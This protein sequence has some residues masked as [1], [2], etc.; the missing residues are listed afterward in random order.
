MTFSVGGLNASGEYADTNL[1]VYTKDSFECDG[2][3]VNPDFEAKGSFE[4]FYYDADGEF[5]G[6]SGTQ[7]STDGE[8]AKGDAFPYAKYARVV[9]TPAVPTNE[10]GVEEEDFKIRFY[11]PAIYASEY[12]ITVAKEQRDV[13]GNLWRSFDSSMMKNGTHDISDNA[14]MGE[15]EGTAPHYHLETD[16]VKGFKSLYLE[17]ADGASFAVFFYNAKKNLIS[18]KSVTLDGEPESIEL[19]NGTCYVCFDFESADQ[20][21]EK[22]YAMK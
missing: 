3:T 13:T 21:G 22:I 5:I 10:D 9:I 20:S 4:V 15:L 12:T 18:W 16:A 1:S 7:E 14:P 11:E 2:L 19:E 17:S 8:Y 6:T